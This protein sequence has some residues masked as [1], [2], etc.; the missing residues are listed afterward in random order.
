VAR[1]FAIGLSGLYI[2]TFFAMLPYRLAW[3]LALEPV[4][5]AC[6]QEVR[7]ILAGRA[8]YAEPSLGY[9]PLVYPPL[10]F[11][12][13]AAVARL[14]GD[15][16]LPLRLLS[17]ACSVGSFVLVFAFVRR[18]TASPLAAFLSVGLFAATFRA[19]GTFFDLARVD[20]LS[21]FLLLAATYLL[22]FSRGAISDVA[23]GVVFSAA[24]LAKQAAL[25]VVAPLVAHAIVT[26]RKGS[27]TL[28]LSAAGTLAVSTLASNALSGG[29]YGYYVVRLPLLAGINPHMIVAF[30]PENVFGRMWFAAI[31]VGAALVA[32]SA[33]RGRDDHFYAVFGA[34]ALAAAWAGRVHLG[35]YKNALLPAYAAL[36]ILFGI[37]LASLLRTGTTRTASLLYVG[38][39]AQLIALFYN[40][41]SCV[42]N[43]GDAAMAERYVAAVRST[44]GNVFV[45]EESEIAERA[46]R[47]GYAS[48]W[49]LLEVLKD[50]GEIRERI[51]RAGADAVRDGKL[52]AMLSVFDDGRELFG[53]DWRTS[54]VRRTIP[55]DGGVTSP[56]PNFYVP[57]YMFVAK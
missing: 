57:M 11:H 37:G 13:S 44:P 34:A 50:D 19:A 48:W 46:G 22:R 39:S 36:A 9:V 53:E 51:L 20:A 29:W 28:A 27:V 6:L 54:Y 25:G 21:L 52:A 35:G 32:R 12:L 5:N 45:P 1:R 42:P 47:D 18:E 15:G 43:A 10:Y 2:A 30:W 4:E 49:A 14:L 56:R 55:D 17:A 38:C 7:R 23:G 26:K 41:I 40:P 8:L 3:P 16:F 31:V 24:V 33:F